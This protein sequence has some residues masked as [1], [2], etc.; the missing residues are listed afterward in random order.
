MI[1]ATDIPIS[2]DPNNTKAAVLVERIVLSLSAIGTLFVL[3][4]V[5]W[6]SN[7]GLD[8]TDESFYLVWISN[9][10]NYSVSATQFG[11]IYYPLYKL[12]G[13]NIAE[14]RQAN[15]LITFGLAWV[16]CNLFLKT[17]FETQTLETT[18][19]L[20]ISAALATSSLVF[21]AT[22]L[23]TPNYNSLTLQALLI[24]ASGLLLAEKKTSRT[25]IA[26]WLLIGVGGWLTFMAKPSTAAAL[27]LCAGVYL[28]LAGKLSVR[29][30]A[31]S[32][33][34]ALG[35][36]VLSA[37]AIDGSIPGFI[38]RLKDGVEA[39]R[40]LGAGQTLAQLLR[41]DDFQLGEKG[42]ALLIV[43]TVVFAS[44]AYF[45]QWQTRPLVFGAALLSISFVLL[46]L[47]IVGG[48]IQKPLNTGPFQGLLIV[49]IPF[50]GIL[51]GLLFSRLQLLINLTRAQ[52]SLALIF[53]IFPHIYA[54]G[55]GNNYWNAGAHAGIFWVLAGLALMGPVASITSL[56]VLLL[57]LG[58]AAQMVTVALIHT[59][60]ESPYRQ[61]GPLR[62]N[63]YKLEIGKPGSTLA[64]S[65]GFGHYFA[66]AINVANQAGFKKGMPMIDLTGQ[67]PGILY[68]IG[69]SNIGQAWTIGGYPG[70]N[71]LATVMLK[72]V[73][74]EELATAWLLVE[75]EGPRK[76]DTDILMSYGASMATDFEVVGT[77]KTAEGAGGYEEVRLQKLFRPVRSSSTAFS[78]CAATRA[79]EP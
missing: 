37:L 50:A 27:G 67:S 64:L 48:F 1:S 49:A 77:F 61:P 70:S 66:E 40:T 63:D 78:S 12:L 20:V 51:V 74:C 26:G 68:A 69:A 44:A 17:V 7:F 72:K 32:L 36:L 33:A 14:L 10:F 57:P 41:V 59:G 16:L 39:A 35:L 2:N 56:S 23:P 42:R 22:W 45:S 62:E 54:F 11:F 43:G 9:P 30:L 21:L 5:L 25:S 46:E 47:A 4:W 3:A 76:I 28:L 19:R 13:G 73:S 65:K 34:S 58:L 55:S 75:P 6:F 53:L 18:R 79:T 71:A 15:I 38:D 24:V 31:I 8:F 52:W 29:L 60:I